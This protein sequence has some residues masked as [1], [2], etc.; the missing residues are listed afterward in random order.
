MMPVMNGYDMLQRVKED[1]QFKD[2]PVV[3]A[4]NLSSGFEEY[5][6]KAKEL[7]VEDYVIKSDISVEELIKKIE[8]YLG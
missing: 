5:L 2:I 1:E 4:T 6:A 3:I 7:G 8:G